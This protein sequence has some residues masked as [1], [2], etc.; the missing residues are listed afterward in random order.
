MAGTTLRPLVDDAAGVPT[1]TSAFSRRR[2]VR[3]R[4]D[5]RAGPR[6]GPRAGRPR[7]I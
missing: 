7:G 2:W 3:S 5:R 4:S 6:P 1:T